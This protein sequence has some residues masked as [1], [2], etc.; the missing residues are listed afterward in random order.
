MVGTAN[1]WE[2][3]SADA[4]KTISATISVTDASLS[5]P[6]IIQFNDVTLGNTEY[7]VEKITNGWRY[8]VNTTITSNMV[9]LRGTTPYDTTYRFFDFE[10]VSSA[11][12][13]T[14]GGIFIDTSRQ[15][16][17][18]NGMTVND[19]KYWTGNTWCY[20]GNATVYAKWEPASP[21]LTVNPNGGTWNGTT[22]NSTFTQK[23]KTTKSIA[24]PSARTG[25]TFAGWELSGGGS[26]N[27]T[28]QNLNFSNGIPSTLNV[29]NNSGNGTVTHTRK[30]MTTPMGNYA[31]EI[32][33]NGTSSPGLGGFY[34]STISVANQKFVHVF[35]AKLPVG[36][37]FMN[38]QNSC[39]TGYTVDW[40]TKKEGT[41]NWEVYAYRT[42][43]GSSG[44]FSSFG[45]VYVNGTGPV[46]WYL[47]SSQVYNE[48]SG[49]TYTFG[50]SNGT[51]TAKWLPKKYK[52]T[53]DNQGATTAGTPAYWYEYQT[54]R[55]VN[56]ITAYYY[57]DSQCTVPLDS[58]YY[59]ENPTKEGHTFEGYFTEKNGAGT[60]Y[61]NKDGMCV[62]NLYNAVAADTTLYAKWTP[63]KYQLDID[64]N[65]GYRV[66]D[67][68][69]NIV[70]VIKAFGETEGISER[71]RDGYSLTGYSVM[72]TESQSA[73]DLGGAKFTFD[74]AAKTGSFVQGSVP[75]TLTAQWKP[76]DYSITYDL[77]GGALPSG[78]TNPVTYNIETATFTLNNPERTGYTFEGWTGTGLSGATKTVTIA[79]GSTG[80]RTYTAT[81]KPIDYS[82]TYNLAG[83]TLPSGKTSPVTYNIETAVTLHAAPTKTGYTFKGWKLENAAGN[84]DAKTYSA[85]QNFAAG[86]YGNITLVAQWTP[87]VYTNY[88]SHW[89]WGF[90]DGEGN[91]SNKA[92]YNIANTSFKAA[93]GSDITFDESRAVEV[94]N[95]FYLNKNSFPENS[96]GPYV[97]HAFPF[98]TKQPAKRVD[99]QYNYELETYD[100]TYVM[101]GG[102]NS[103]SNKATYNVLYGFELSD[104]TKKG[105]TF[106]GWYLNGEKVTGI[107]EDKI[108][109]TDASSLYSALE[110]RM[111]GDITLEARW[112]VN[113][114]TNKI[115]H[116]AYGFEQ[117]EG[118]NGTGTAY[119]IG[120]TTSDAV[121]DTD[122]TFD[123]TSA[124][125]VPNGFYL[126]TDSFKEDSSGTYTEHAMPYT[127]KQPDKG[128]NAQY[129]YK[130]YTYDV[131]YVMNG[132]V[133]PSSNKTTYN[134][135]YGFTLEDPAERPGYTFNGW[136][137]NGTK[138]T[139]INANPLTFTSAVSLYSALET[140]L[141]GDITLEAKWTLNEYSITYKLDGG[142]LPSGKTNPTKYTVESD[143]F[144]LVQPQKT[145]YSFLGWTGSNGTTPQRQVT[146]EKGSTGN[147]TYI[148]NWG[149][150]EYT[151]S[152]DGNGATSGTMGDQNISVDTPTKLNVNKFSRTGYLFDGWNTKADGSGDSYADE[153]KVTNL[154]TAGTKITLYAQW[155]RIY[156]YV[157]VQKKTSDSDLVAGNDN[158]SLE[159]AEYTVYDSN[160]NKI[161][162]MTTDDK[163]KS[164]TIYIPYGDYKVVETKASP[165]YKLDP[166]EH[167]VKIRTMDETVIV[168]SNEEPYKGV[169]LSAGI[170][171]TAK[172][173]N[174][175]D[176]YNDVVEDPKD[177]NDKQFW[178]GE[179]FIIGGEFFYEDD[180]YINPHCLIYKVEITNASAIGG[181]KYEYSFK[182]YIENEEYL[183]DIT[184]T[185]DGFILKQKGCLWNEDMVNRWGKGTHDLTFK[186]TY[187]D[188]KTETV[189][190]TVNSREAYYKLHRVI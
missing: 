62:N 147:R 3:T 52:V 183:D 80:N 185:E 93:Y 184:E 40:L 64:P 118:N 170:Y 107:N 54:T 146:I 110:T 18:A 42:N 114:Y 117:G 124:V 16:Y 47:A 96:S 34:N 172:W 122:V 91:N 30:A 51:L 105:H 71:R 94:P 14:I 32:K 108:V 180:G 162:V 1:G 154:T 15:V 53:L 99:A 167:E 169:K 59:I 153:E 159:G 133:K 23:Y 2:M 101:N 171:H 17:G 58:G 92:A 106:E 19:G 66:S 151:V 142:A 87:T 163:G 28:G 50:T 129:S 188:G 190:V 43:C 160:G 175:R 81:W 119:R 120:E 156:G 143:T 46:T 27:V 187:V 139:G 125:E 74:S 73:T 45:H 121:Y 6:P 89:A 155:K 84:W 4:G 173:D 9:S 77:V 177:R 174:N 82:I 25:W 65:G 186:F 102:T 134:V 38:A 11:A 141:T 88:I 157:R 130:P 97:S 100:I 83:G 5:S 144:T 128:I 8:T 29:Y 136:Y 70:T 67:G 12:K 20:L 13:A 189:N 26:F 126:D 22:S 35:V 145:G 131:T 140:R 86:K 165:G 60:Q 150:M 63:N 36:Y 135:L 182:N 149:P 158:Y 98:T 179:K 21:T 56:G 61:V 115:T 55:V 181:G 109:F 48:T 78:K 31:I 95:G 112:S 41:G 44:S 79:K 161:G 37:S 152:F 113:T 137:L 72:N 7:V 24:A 123:S 90:K 57:K 127:T 111:T 148:A 39:G 75:I 103:S 69:K 132:G 166:E 49:N 138:V 178:A 68:N 76:I 10:G 164:N 116:W 85:S 104:P 168:S 176:I 33:N